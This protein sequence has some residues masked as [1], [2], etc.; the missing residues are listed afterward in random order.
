MSDSNFTGS[1]SSRFLE[2][3]DNWIVFEPLSSDKN[4]K[5]HIFSA[6]LG[7]QVLPVLSFNSGAAE[8]ND[9]GILIEK[10]IYKFEDESKAYE[11]VTNIG[12]ENLVSIEEKIIERLDGKRYYDAE[13]HLLNQEEIEIEAEMQ[14]FQISKGFKIE[15]WTSGSIEEGGSKKISQDYLIKDGSIISDTYLQYFTIITDD[16]DA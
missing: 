12:E 13:I 7:S 1:E 4:M 14:D 5:N 8:T 16:E 6:P 11:F 15:I 2:V 9:K 10:L 3:H